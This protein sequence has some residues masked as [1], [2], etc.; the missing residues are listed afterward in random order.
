MLDEFDAVLLSLLCLILFAVFILLNML[1]V[2]WLSQNLEAIIKLIENE[3]ILKIDRTINQ[4]CV[5]IQAH[6]KRYDEGRR[7]IRKICRWID[8]GNYPTL[9]Y[10]NVFSHY[11]CNTVK[12]CKKPDDSVYDC[13][14]DCIEDYHHQCK[15]YED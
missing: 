4:R 10:T 6:P 3:T 12:V 7:Y 8:Q 15:S 5:Y 1:G 9:E 11:D 2:F 14:I 13:L